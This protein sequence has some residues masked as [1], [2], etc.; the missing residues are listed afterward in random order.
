MAFYRELDPRLVIIRKTADEIISDNQIL[1]NDAELKLP[2]GVNSV[3][4]FEF[5]LFYASDATPDF[6]ED[7]AVPAGASM[8]WVYTA[9]TVPLAPYTEATTRM[10]SGSGAVT[11]KTATH[12]GVVVCG[13]TAG[14]L[15]YT[16]SQDVANVSNTT[17][18]ENSCI[19]AHRLK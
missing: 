19:I 5:R 17:V 9:S 2:M 10:L 16:W 7:W 8:W 1:H 11:V 12:M 4:A 3:W 14:N 18:F 13:A 6:S 15:Q